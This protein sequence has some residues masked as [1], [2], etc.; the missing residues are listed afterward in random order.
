VAGHMSPHRAGWAT[1]AL[2]LCLV[3]LIAVTVLPN[4]TPLILLSVFALEGVLLLAR[5]P[6]AIRI[7]RRGFG[8]LP[9]PTEAQIDALTRSLVYTNPTYV[10]FEPAVDLRL[11]TDDQLDKAWRDSQSALV[12]CSGPR[13]WLRAVEERG[14]YLAEFERRQPS[15]LRAWLTSEAGAP[16]MLLPYA[17]AS[18]L[19]PP[20]IDWDELTGG[21]ATDR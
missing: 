16:D 4:R 11:L 20:T 8:S 5:L 12:T 6:R 19:E 7:C 3:G 17:K 15:L 21:Q 1:A 2:S 10:P 9:R 18:R 13:D 14:R